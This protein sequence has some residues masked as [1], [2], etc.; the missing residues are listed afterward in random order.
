MPLVHREP[1]PYQTE[2]LAAW[3]RAKGRGV[4]VLPTGAGKSHVATCSQS[5]T[6]AERARVAPTLDLVRQWYDLLGATFG[7]PIGV[8]GG[9]EH[10]VQALTVTTYDSAL[11]S[12]GPPRRALRAR[13]LRRVP[14]PP[15]R[16]RT[17]WRRARASPPSASGSR[18]RPSAPT[19]GTR[20]SRARRADRLPKGHRRALGRLSRRVRRRAGR[21]S[22]SRP[23]ERAE[24]DAERA[25][26][27]EFVGMHGIR[28]SSPSGWGEFVHLASRERT[29]GGARWPRTG[30]SARSRSRAPAK[31]DYLG[32]LLARAPRRPRA[33]SSPRTTPR[34]TPSR[35]ASSSRSSP[36][37]RRC[38]SGA[39]SSPG[40]P[41]GAFRAVA[42]SKV[43][44]EGV[45]VPDA[46]V[47]V[48]LS[49]SG[50]VREHVQ[51]LGRILRKREGKRAVLYELVTAATSETYTSERRREH[52][53]YR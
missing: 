51:R 34:P 26:Y 2:A 39:P 23:T 24:H 13:R 7:V 43:L 16:L 40:S 10:D 31:L 12:H 52:G 14:P 18:R 8:V 4:V 11:P 49:G 1:R 25:I 32:H 30:G 36:T 28:M 17:R 19:G 35:A 27:R 38:A 50:S 15:E 33:S 22:S 53:A 48:V 44:N 29:T 47:A 9:G 42:T 46:N 5:T 21:R 20:S 6:A 45:D 3:K 37:R 41:A